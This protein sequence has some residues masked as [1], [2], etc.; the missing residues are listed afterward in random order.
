MPSPTT[1]LQ[2][3]KDALA[4]TNVIGVDQ[5]LTADETS[6]CLRKFN[7][8]IEYWSTFSLAVYGQANQTFNTVAN[9]KVYTIGTG[10][11]WSTTRPVRINEPSY[12][13][14]NSISFQY[15]SMTQQ[16]YNLI[17]YK[18]QPGGGTDLTQGYLY[19][20]DYPLG[21]VTLW[22]VPNAVFPITWSID[23]VLSQIAT[24]ATSIS[25]P[26]GTI[27]AFVYMLGVRLAPVFGKVPSEDVKQQAKDSWGAIKRANKQPQELRYDTAILGN[28]WYNWRSG[29]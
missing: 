1:A 13:T 28:Q 15:V 27:D 17:G 9:Q 7:D 23:R 19:V 25:F 14:I 12:A 11:D 8:L 4:L 29:T 3:I 6:D 21:I 16:E 20:N 22:P 26:P 18:D 10:G 24:A 5:T 2:V